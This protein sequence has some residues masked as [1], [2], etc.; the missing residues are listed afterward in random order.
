MATQDVSFPLPTTPLEL[1]K[2]LILRF[3]DAE[4]RAFFLWLFPPKPGAIDLTENERELLCFIAN[5]MTEEAI[6]K[7]S[8]IDSKTV[9]LH[10]KHLRERLNVKSS[11][12]MIRYAVELGLVPPLFSARPPKAKLAFARKQSPDT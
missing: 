8:G 10:K 6:A 12:E 4:H 11:A 9:Q 1:V 7:Q 3:S 2:Y 5:G